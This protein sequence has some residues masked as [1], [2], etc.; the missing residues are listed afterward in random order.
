MTVLMC[1]TVMNTEQNMQLNVYDRRMLRF[2]RTYVG[3]GDMSILSHVY[4]YSPE[5]T[6]QKLLR[7]KRD[8]IR[9]VERL[10]PASQEW[11]LLYYLFIYGNVC[12]RPLVDVMML[13]RRSQITTRS[14]R[15]RRTA[16]FALLRTHATPS[17][18][19]AWRAVM[20]SEQLSTAGK[21][22]FDGRDC[23]CTV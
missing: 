15:S 6:R 4:H 23:G 19:V 3:Y 10:P 14:E 21:I 20:L 5:A 7:V 18:S 13:T 16:G 11:Q 8:I 17:T 1:L 12:S 22:V 9:G 2:V